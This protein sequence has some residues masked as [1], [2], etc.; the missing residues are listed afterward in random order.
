MV[1]LPTASSLIVVDLPAP[2]GFS[3][4]HVTL[5][6]GES[7]VVLD[8]ESKQQL[9]DE[10]PISTDNS[11]YLNVDENTLPVAPVPGLLFQY[12][13]AGQVAI[14]RLASPALN[15]GTVTYQVGPGFHTERNG[16]NVQLL[17][18]FKIYTAVGDFSYTCVTMED[19]WPC[20]VQYD[21]TGIGE[22]FELDTGVWLRVEV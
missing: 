7:F 16:F 2:S 22:F 15:H 9:L 5:P 8:P 11:D 1:I 21:Q 10:T 6:D 17:P 4:N 18:G 12:V 3:Y 14:R 13:T 19:Y 20:T